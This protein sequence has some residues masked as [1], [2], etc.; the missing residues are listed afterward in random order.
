LLWSENY[1][2]PANRTDQTDEGPGLS[3][4]S[5]PISGRNTRIR[6]LIASVLH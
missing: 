3:E 2:Y 1:L 6:D 5:N 4:P